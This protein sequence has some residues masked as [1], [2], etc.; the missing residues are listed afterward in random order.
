MLP[1]GSEQ[2]ASHLP[3]RIA[4]LRLAQPFDGV[5]TAERE[6]RIAHPRTPLLVGAEHDTALD[7][8]A[9]AAIAPDRQPSEQDRNQ[10]RCQTGFWEAESSLTAERFYSSNGYLIRER[11]EH[12]LWN[13]QRMASIKMRK[14]IAVRNS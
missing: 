1:P 12:V 4:R 11:G 6:Q 7:S 3:H 2:I 5:A 14:T 8:I 9:P 13:G 10:A